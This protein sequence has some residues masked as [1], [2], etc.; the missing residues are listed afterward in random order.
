MMINSNGFAITIL[1]QQWLGYAGKIQ[2]RTPYDVIPMLIS[3]PVAE[4]RWEGALRYTAQ[5]P[6]IAASPC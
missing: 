4:A 1:L 3:R 5:G 6:P 2:H